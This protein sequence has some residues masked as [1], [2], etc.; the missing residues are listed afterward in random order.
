MRALFLLAAVA[1]LS[2]CAT[3]LPPADPQQAWV[4]MRYT[5]GEMLM[6]EALD[7]RVVHDGR[8]FSVPPGQHVLR[9]SYRYEVAGS[10]N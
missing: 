6:A 9:V 2:A 8:Y 1:L 5:P 4:A 7:E 3:P 10:G